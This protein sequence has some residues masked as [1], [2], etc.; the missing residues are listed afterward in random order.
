MKVTTYIMTILLLSLCGCG[1]MYFPQNAM[2]DPADGVS[3]PHP[4]EAERKGVKEITVFTTIM[5]PGLLTEAIANSGVWPSVGQIPGQDEVLEGY[6]YLA[7]L[8]RYG[9]FMLNHVFNYPEEI[10]IQAKFLYLN[11]DGGTAYKLDGTIIPEKDYDPEKFDKNKEYCSQFF[12]KYGMTLAELDAI[13]RKYIVSNECSFL[14]GDGLFLDNTCAA[15]VAQD[16]G[17]ISTTLGIKVGSEEWENYKE[18]V[19]HI[20]NH[21]QKMPDGEIR[22][23]NLDLNE[24]RK[25]A[26]KNNG[27][28]WGKRFLKNSTIPLSL[29]IG[30]STGPAGYLAASNVVGDALNAGIDT[31]LK[32]HY[33]RATILAKELKPNFRAVVM[34]YKYRL[35][36]RDSV[37][38]DLNLRIQD[39]KRK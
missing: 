9:D 6:A 35:K 21:N 24:F 17:D 16:V 8:G 1:G 19:S 5:D 26:V 7:D 37:I 39:Y 33:D 23:T 27:S 30:I 18:R 36:E 4:V 28:N 34:A 38:R 20:M 15:K 10:V 11:R 2:M 3:I 32:G 12:E 13:W 14:E 22:M 25:D 29:L 31:S